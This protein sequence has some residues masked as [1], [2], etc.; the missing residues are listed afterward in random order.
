MRLSTKGAK[1]IAREEGMILHPYNDPVGYATVGIGH[2]LHRSRVTLLDKIRWARFR[3]ADAYKLLQKDAERFAEPLRRHAA[4]RHWNLTQAQFDALVSF[5]FNV[6]TGWLKSSTLERVLTD[7][8]RHKHRPSPSAVKAAML[9]WSKAGGR[10]LVGLRQ[11]RAREA[12]LFSY[13]RYS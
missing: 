9:M 3:Q 10:T 6:G 7:A 11:R 12:K 13:G 2:L 1:F 8:A 4:L 5:S